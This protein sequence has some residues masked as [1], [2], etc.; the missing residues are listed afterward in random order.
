MAKPPATSAMSTA[1]PRSPQAT[2]RVGALPSD[3]VSTMATFT[4]ST[5]WATA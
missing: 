3:V 4:S 5:P 2:K 1:I